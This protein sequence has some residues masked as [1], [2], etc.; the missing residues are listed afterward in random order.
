[1]TG[2]LHKVNRM[3]KC[4]DAAVKQTPQLD[5]G[6]PYVIR[7]MFHLNCPRPLKSVTKAKE[8]FQRALE[9]FRYLLLSL[10][11]SIY[12]LSWIL[13]N[14]GSCLYSMLTSGHWY[15][16]DAV[17]SLNVVCRWTTRM[18]GTCISVV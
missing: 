1:M 5:S 4:I 8:N 9:V 7:G 3:S 6:M 10:L 16:F 11:V 12:S 2:A 18:G 14:L 17:S 15:V 13:C